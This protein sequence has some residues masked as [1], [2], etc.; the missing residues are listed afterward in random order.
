MADESWCS[1]ASSTI[2]TTAAGSFTQS[3]ALCISYD[4]TYYD[5]D[6]NPNTA[7]G[8]STCTDVAPTWIYQV[9]QTP[10]AALADHF[11]ISIDAKTNKIWLKAQTGGTNYGL[12][13]LNVNGYLP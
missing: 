1:P 8:S 3:N 6:F 7:T 13:T 10:M 2:T 4:N 11:K 5:F 12:F 9:D